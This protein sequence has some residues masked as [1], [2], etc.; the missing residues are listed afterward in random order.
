ME[1]LVVKRAHSCLL[2]KTSLI[3]VNKGKRSDLTKT[4]SVIPPYITS[5]MCID[6]AK[7]TSGLSQTVKST[8][9]MGGKR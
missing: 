7:S 6:F 9:G 8:V 2:H 5:C 4:V 1:L 3:V